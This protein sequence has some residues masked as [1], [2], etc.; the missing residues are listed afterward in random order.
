MNE[1]FRSVISHSS[2]DKV[3]IVYSWYGP[4]GPLWNTELPNILT[5]SSAAEGVNP[6][7]TSRNFWTDDVWQKQFSKAKD[8]YELYP[9][10][11]IEADDK[12]PFIY[13]FSLTWRVEFEKY[14][15]SNSGIL[16]FSHIPHW[17]IHLCKT[18]NGYILI[19]HS[20]EAF[21]SD[22]E[23]DAMYSYFHEAHR[24][25]MYKIIYLTG[26]VNASYVYEDWCKRKGIADIREHRMHVIPYASSREIFHSFVLN[27]H[28]SNITTDEHAQGVTQVT[29]PEY[30]VN[31]LPQKLFLS[32]N[33]RLRE[34]RIFLA[35]TLE[36]IG[37]V[38]R[39]YVS[40]AKQSD[41]N[42]SQTFEGSASGLQQNNNIYGLQF[43]QLFSEETVNKFSA[44]L[45]LV[46]DG[47]TDVNIMCEDF[48]YTKDFYHNSLVSL[49]TET[50][51]DSVECTLTEKSF[52][53]MFNKHPFIIIGV[54][55]A[56]QGLKDLGFKTFDNFWDE[57]YDNEPQPGL[58]FQK[59][60]KVLTEIA[61]WNEHQ[62]LSF[63]TRVKPIL[64][65]NYSM[66]KESGAVPVTSNMYEHIT[67]NFNS[68]WTDWCN[69]DPGY[70]KNP[71]YDPS[72]G[73]NTTQGVPKNEQQP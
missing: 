35:L 32:W 21:M 38:N 51:Y 47:E 29:E 12:R 59:I 54:P 33:R 55:G 66:F 5:F 30:D 62:I 61:S 24:I 28:G 11:S 60:T 20:V 4:H 72:T 26:T 65:Y 53:P 44:R 16:E 42:S 46:I 52:K 13:P 6:N 25:P 50:N 39:S 23:L 31:V 64:D 14:F 48:H 56:L 45:P 71:I 34:H 9:V 57:S 58:R 43:N 7:M 27:G 19:D 49:V 37:V 3:K 17:L 15:L 67:K 36:E 68:D 69:G 2:D 70:C 41:E 73:N 1:K 18:G 63:K 40:F 8:K 10:A 22:T